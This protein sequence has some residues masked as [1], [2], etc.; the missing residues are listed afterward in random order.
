MRCVEAACAGPT[1]EA[2]DQVE[3][4]E[5]FKVM[6]SPESNALRY[7]FFAERAGAK[8]KVQYLPNICD[9]S[10]NIFYTDMSQSTKT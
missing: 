4:K 10:F 2:G 3:K 8:V 6:R 7:M 5:F 9:F 1:F